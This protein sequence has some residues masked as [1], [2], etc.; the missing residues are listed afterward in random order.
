VLTFPVNV[1]CFPKRHQLFF[2]AVGTEFFVSYEVK[3]Y[4]SLLVCRT[5]KNWRRDGMILTGGT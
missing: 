1:D 3:S 4:P 2:F 5:S